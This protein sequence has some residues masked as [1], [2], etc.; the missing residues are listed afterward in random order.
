[1]REIELFESWLNNLV[2]STVL[3]SSTEQQQE[4]EQ[5]LS[6]PLPVGADGTNAT[7]TLARLFMDPEM[8]DDLKDLAQTDPNADARPVV[9]SRMS[10]YRSQ[11][12]IAAL[13]AKISNATAQ[14]EQPAEPGPDDE[15]VDTAA[16]PAPEAPPAPAK[17]PAAQQPPEPPAGD[18]IE[19][20]QPVAE[21]DAD[22]DA[23]LAAILKH[24]GVSDDD[25][26]APNYVV[27]SN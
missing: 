9:M 12:G 8:Q 20:E 16:A 21:S 26:P 18:E 7:E 3:P 11:P 17:A 1:M 27:G 24:A 6:E 10:A 2:E 4:L 14:D 25:H 22:Y 13:M 5:V 23:N 15:A 19:P